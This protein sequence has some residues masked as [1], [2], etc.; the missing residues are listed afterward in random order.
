MYSNSILVQY[1]KVEVYNILEPK[2]IVFVNKSNMLASSSG[3]VHVLGSLFTSS[4]HYMLYIKI[5]LGNIGGLVSGADVIEST[6]GLSLL[7][8]IFSLLVRT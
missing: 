8:R 7:P 3:I 4:Y 2:N 1:V 5:L 6:R